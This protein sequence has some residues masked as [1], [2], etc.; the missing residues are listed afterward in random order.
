LA[1][2]HGLKSAAVTVNVEMTVDILIMKLCTSDGAIRR[3]HDGDFWVSAQNG[4][5]HH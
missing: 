2:S 3:Y 5:Q 4:Q 1:H